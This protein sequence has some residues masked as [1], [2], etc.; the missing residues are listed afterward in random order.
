MHH[1][2]TTG[3]FAREFDALGRWVQIGVASGN[4]ISVSFPTE[5]EAE[6]EENAVLDRI[7]AYL[8]GEEDAL[9]HV[10]VALTVPTDQRTVL[11][12]VRAIPYGQAVGVDQVARMAAGLE[13]DEGGWEVVERALSANP[14]PILIPDHRVVDGPSGA[15]REVVSKLQSLEGLA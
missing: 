9:S 7:G 6:S 10:E 4:V 3:V 1:D 11:E 14:V 5:P 2:G 8:D 13:D 15:P 12:T